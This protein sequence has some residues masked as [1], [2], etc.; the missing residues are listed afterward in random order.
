MTPHLHSNF[1]L[2]LFKTMSSCRK[3]FKVVFAKS[4]SSL[5]WFCQIRS[6]ASDGTHTQGFFFQFCD[7]A[8]VAIISKVI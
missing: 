5:Q 8:D 7:V 4:S 1:L 2:I 6:S 3:E